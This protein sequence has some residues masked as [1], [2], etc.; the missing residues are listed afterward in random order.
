MS[1]LKEPVVIA[2]LAKRNMEQE[3]EIEELNKRIDS[4]RAYIY[5]IGGP[6]ND[7]RLQYNK[8][9]LLTFHNI[10][11]CLLGNY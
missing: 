8:E 9:Q 10:N 5:C 2:E 7:N 1:Q 4:A 11:E 6:L 3:F